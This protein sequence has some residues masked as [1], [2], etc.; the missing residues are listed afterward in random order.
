MCFME[1]QNGSGNTDQ[2]DHKQ[3]HAA[4]YKDDKPSPTSCF[5]A[6]RVD[7]MSTLIHMVCC[8]QTTLHC[9]LCGIKNLHNNVIVNY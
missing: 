2:K 4:H 7:V 9:V 1:V 8:C 3:K 5:E 6:L